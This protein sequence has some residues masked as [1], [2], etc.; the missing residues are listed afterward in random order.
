[1]LNAKDCS[2]FRSAYDGLPDEGGTILV[3]AGTYG[4][5]SEDD[6]G[7]FRGLHITTKAVVLQGEGAARRDGVNFGLARRVHPVPNLAGVSYPGPVDQAAA[8]RTVKGSC[9]LP[10]LTEMAFPIR[11]RRSLRRNDGELR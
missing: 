10:V 7:L 2:A 4:Y 8:A 3:P 9:T 6:K 11:G 5:T 1:M